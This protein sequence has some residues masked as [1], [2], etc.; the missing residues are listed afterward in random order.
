MAELQRRRNLGAAALAQ[1]VE[2][3]F[4]HFTGGRIMDDVAPL[5]MFVILLQPGVDP[6]RGIAHQ[7]FLAFAHGTG[8]V[9][10]VDDDR[11]GLGQG[12]GFVG[13][14]API[15]TVG[16]NDWVF[17]VVTPRS[18]LALERFAVGALKVA[19][20]FRPDPANICVPCRLGL[21]AFIAFGLNT[22]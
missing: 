5:Y 15:L 22:G 17:G 4:V 7:P 16:D 18:H 6:K 13:T 3:G 2:R 21:D 12:L 14:I 20:R 1:P 11:I 9:H 19:Q 10:H 8:N